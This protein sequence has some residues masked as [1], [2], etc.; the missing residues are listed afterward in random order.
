MQTKPTELLTLAETFSH[1]RYQYAKELITL[2]ETF[3]RTRFQ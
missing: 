3:S 1:N 2:A